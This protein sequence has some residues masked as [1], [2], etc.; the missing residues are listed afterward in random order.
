M[1]VRTYC[2][3]GCFTRPPGTSTRNHPHE[4]TTS[5][6]VVPGGYVCSH[7]VYD[8][9]ASDL[10]AGQARRRPGMRPA[11]TRLKDV[12]K[13]WLRVAWAVISACE[14][15]MRME[16]NT[17]TLPESAPPSYEPAG[18]GTTT[19]G[20]PRTALALASA[21]RGPAAQAG[22]HQAPAGADRRRDHRAA[23][24]AQDDPPPA[25]EDQAADHGRDDAGLDRRLHD[26][27][28]GLVRRRLRRAAARARDRAT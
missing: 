14:N 23:G 28:G 20:R 5:K 2:F 9:R 8:R 17:P 16:P 26:D 27:L 24:E 22:L 15:E 6:P 1:R 12:D 3:P 25:A 4:P 10:S 19:A 21:A 11:E 13:D 7:P 18:F